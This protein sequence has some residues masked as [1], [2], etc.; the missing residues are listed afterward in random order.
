M[1]DSDMNQLIDPEQV[2]GYLITMF[3][4]EPFDIGNGMTSQVLGSLLEGIVQAIK[5]TQAASLI[6][7]PAP[8][9][10]ALLIA[11]GWVSEAAMQMEGCDLLALRSG[12]FDLYYREFQ[13]ST[14]QT[15]WDQR[16]QHRLS[17]GRRP[18]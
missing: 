3:N 6:T 18:N 10:M 5:G 16:A 1:R 9:Y 15:Y 2:I 12:C 4:E 11:D 17:Y 14:Y 7:T 13:E 8:M